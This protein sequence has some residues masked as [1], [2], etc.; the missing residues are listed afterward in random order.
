MNMADKKKVDELAEAELIDIIERIF[1][2]KYKL[3]L[4]DSFGGGILYT[5]ITI[6]DITQN[7]KQHLLKLKITEPV[8]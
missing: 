7:V 6:P 5:S 8:K 4:R 1:P 3:I 2:N